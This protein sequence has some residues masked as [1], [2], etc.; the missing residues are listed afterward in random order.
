VKYVNSR[1]NAQDE[2]E[3]FGRAWGAGSSGQAFGDERGLCEARAKVQHTDKF[4][5]IHSD[6]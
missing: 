1:Y 5:D 2:K 3:Q 4:N 6:L